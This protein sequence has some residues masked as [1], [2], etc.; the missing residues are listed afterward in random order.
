[1]K[2]KE[3]IEQVMHKITKI[4]EELKGLYST[5]ETVLICNGYKYQPSLDTYDTDETADKKMNEIL[6]TV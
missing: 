6:D 4:N 1:M 2:N 3:Q 5:L